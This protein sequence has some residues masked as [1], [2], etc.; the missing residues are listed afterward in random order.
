MRHNVSVGALR[1]PSMLI[2]HSRHPFL[3]T[4]AFS[5]SFL[6]HSINYY[7]INHYHIYLIGLYL[8][9]QLDT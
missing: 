2:L 8:K 3:N 7:P 4:H 6:K 5:F 1:T 9:L